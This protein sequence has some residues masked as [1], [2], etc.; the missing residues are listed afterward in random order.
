MQDLLNEN[1]QKLGNNVYRFRVLKRLTQ[2]KLAE[3]CEITGAYISQIE[4]ADLHRSVTYK[5]IIKIAESLGIPPCVLVSTEP[6]PKYMECLSAS[7]VNISA[8][9]N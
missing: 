4:R 1:Y 2:D 9:K 5:T 8:N 6:C 7:T 3:Q